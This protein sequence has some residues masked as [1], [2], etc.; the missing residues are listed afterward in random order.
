LREKSGFFFRC[1]ISGVPA[2]GPSF[3][4]R[5]GTKTRRDK[6][7]DLIQLIRNR[8]RQMLAKTIGATWAYALAFSI[9]FAIQNSSTAQVVPNRAP[10]VEPNQAPVELNQAPAIV[11][12]NV[13][14]LGAHGP[15]G[16]A[17]RTYYNCWNTGCEV[18]AEDRLELPTASVEIESNPPVRPSATV[19]AGEPRAAR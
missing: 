10:V 16:H 11:R 15:R 17:L 6:F 7:Y 2:L 13:T 9:L 5:A 1:A 4:L 3:A 8:I 14:V 18:V 12:H 19:G